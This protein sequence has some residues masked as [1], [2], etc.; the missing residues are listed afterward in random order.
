MNFGQAIASGFR[1]YAT[2]AGRASRSEYWYWTLFSV[3][4][5]VVAGILDAA[6]FPFSAV[7][8]LSAISTI[9]LLLPGIAVAARRLH[10]I[11]RTGWWLLI[12]LTGIGVILLIIWDCFRGTTG[13]NRFGADPLAA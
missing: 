11:D 12:M 3:L 8:P 13:S 6:I 7:S 10:D 1:N 9:L 4:V 5:S 2:F